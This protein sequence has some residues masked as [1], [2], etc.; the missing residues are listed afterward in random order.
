MTSKEHCM[1]ARA[2]DITEGVEILT[3]RCIFEKVKKVHMEIA[4]STSDEDGVYFYG[5]KSRWLGPYLRHHLV[6][7]RTEEQS[8][9]V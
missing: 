7:Y 9:E 8:G 2:E 1:V 3:D 4:G 5:E 6:A